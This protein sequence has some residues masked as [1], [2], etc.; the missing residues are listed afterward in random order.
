M[1][2]TVRVDPSIL[3]YR[4]EI[5]PEAQPDGS[6]VY[7]AEI[8]DLPGCMSHGTTV[9]E[10]RQNLEDAKR[11][12]LAALMDRQLVI[13]TPSESA[14]VGVTWNVFMAGSSSEISGR[15]GGSVHLVTKTEQTLVDCLVHSPTGSR[16]SRRPDSPLPEFPRSYLLSFHASPAAS[17]AES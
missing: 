2:V 11:E 10:A 13:P 8:P 6:I 17:S 1:T 4:T 15:S 16:P 5:R 12:Y 9:D 7:M 3:Q 14:V